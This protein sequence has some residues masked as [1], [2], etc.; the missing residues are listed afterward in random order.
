MNKVIR[1]I[2]T[3]L[4]CAF[5]FVIA[6]MARKQE[7]FT[8]TSLTWELLSWNLML[9]FVVLIV[10]LVML[11]TMPRVR[12][13]TL[14][15]LANLKERDEHEEYIT[16]KASRAAYI[17]TLSLMIFI[18][19]FSIFSFSYYR[20]PES[21]AID[22]KRNTVSVN[23]GFNLLGGDSQIIYSPGTEMLFTTKDFSLSTSSILFILIGWQLLSFN[24]AARKE[25][26]RE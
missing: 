20:L 19:F 21:Q 10:F 24:I 14:R 12:E 13:K 16:G 25:Q 11:V 3:Y 2:Q 1:F 4:V 23:A 9:W 15:R 22:G 18:L 5:P 26:D 8:N 17:S 7:S 6:C